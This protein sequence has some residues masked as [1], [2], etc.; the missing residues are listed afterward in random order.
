MDKNQAHR[1]TSEAAGETFRVGPALVEVAAKTDRKSPYALFGF[2]FLSISTAL[3][4]TPWLLV[5][6]Q[7]VVLMVATCW[8]SIKARADHKSS[9]AHGP[10]RD[11]APGTPKAERPPQEVIDVPGGKAIRFRR[12]GRETPHR[13]NSKGRRLMAMTHRPL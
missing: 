12:I 7:A 5:L 13:S 9:P 10:V 2:Y 1:Q 11:V 3:D 8:Q 6:V 4:S